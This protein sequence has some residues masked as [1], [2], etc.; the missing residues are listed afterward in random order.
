MRWTTLLL[1]LLSV[2]LLAAWPGLRDAL[3]VTVTWGVQSPPVIV[4]GMAATLWRHLTD[5]AR[6]EAA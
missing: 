2:L 3:L 6:G 4:A 5:S 1:A